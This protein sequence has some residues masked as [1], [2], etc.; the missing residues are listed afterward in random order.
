MERGSGDENPDQ[1]SP[2]LVCEL[3]LAKNGRGHEATRATSRCNDQQQRD[4]ET[5][6][7]RE[8]GLNVKK[9]PVSWLDVRVWA[10][11]KAAAAAAAGPRYC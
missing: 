5:S 1:V 9:G 8:P 4:H 6:A 10:P 2:R 11:L 7:V 3:F